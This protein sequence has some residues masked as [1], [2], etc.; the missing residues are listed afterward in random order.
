VGGC[1]V[2]KKKQ[3]IVAKLTERQITDHGVRVSSH[4]ARMNFWASP[5]ATAMFPSLATVALRQQS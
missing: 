4:A 2:L 5:A 1:R 3:T